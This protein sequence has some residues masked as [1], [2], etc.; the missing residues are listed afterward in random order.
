MEAVQ[1][2]LE[3]VAKRAPG[4]HSNSTS[5]KAA[6]ASPTVHDSIDQ[7]IA[8]IEAA[9]TSVAASSASSSSS[10]PHPAVVIAE[11]KSAVEWTQKAVLDCQR[12]FHAAFPS[13]QKGSTRSYISCNSSHGWLVLSR[14]G[15]HAYKNLSDLQPVLLISLREANACMY[16]CSPRQRLW[17]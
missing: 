8:R 1:K 13:P 7:L 15:K 16:P 14:S 9:K 2:S 10:Q 12:E 4:L 17:C 3:H 6:A 11:L 5:A